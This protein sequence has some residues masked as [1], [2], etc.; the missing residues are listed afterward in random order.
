[1]A[2]NSV[3]APWATVEDLPAGGPCTA[4]TPEIAAWLQVASEILY[5]FTK[6]KYPGV[7][8]DVIRPVRPCWAGEYAGTIS[9]HITR[10]GYHAPRWLRLCSCGCVDSIELP[11]QPVVDVIEVRLDGV[12]LD[13]VNYRLDNRRELVRLA[14]PQ[15]PACQR[16]KLD[17]DQPGT[18]Q[19]SYHFGCA[20]A[21][22]GADGGGARLSA[23]SRIVARSEGVPTAE[24]RA[25]GDAPERHTGRARPADAVQGRHDRA[26]EVDL[27]VAAD[28]R[29][30][31]TR[32]AAVLDPM[33]VA[34]GLVPRRHR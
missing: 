2:P 25:D 30:D 16:M 33:T 3:L 11:L 13:P 17:V 18:W 4:D 21:R 22:R 31:A 15:W 34:R 7:G 1:M 23:R 28:A 10:G 5:N 6:R 14:G 24:A 12:V 32:P 29:G 26:R 8:L 27:W 19:V 9:S 20:A